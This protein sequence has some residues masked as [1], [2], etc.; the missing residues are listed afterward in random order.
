MERGKRPNANDARGRN[1]RT[2]APSMVAACTRWPPYGRHTNG[3]VRL[4]YPVL[5]CPDRPLT[6]CLRLMTNRLLICLAQR[7]SV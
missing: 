1:V 5:M 7:G 3:R 2:S 4:P 6:A